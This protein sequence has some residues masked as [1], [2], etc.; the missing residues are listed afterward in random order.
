MGV[1]EQVLAAKQQ[2]NSFYAKKA[3]QKAVEQYTEAEK[4]AGGSE[5]TSV[6]AELAKVLNNRAACFLALGR[7]VRAIADCSNAI[8]LTP[9][10]A[11]AFFRR[12]QAY[13]DCCKFSAAAEDLRKLL[14]LDPTNERGK[15]MLRLVEKKLHKAT[16]SRSKNTN[17]DPAEVQVTRDDQLK[18]NKFGVL[19]AELEEL[20]DS[21]REARKQLRNLEAAC[22]DVALLD[23]DDEDDEVL[24]RVGEVFIKVNPDEAEQI[25]E[26]QKEEAET[27]VAN[28]ESR[29]GAVLQEMELLRTTLYAKFGNAIGL[30]LPRDDDEE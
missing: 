10:Y 27:L 22:E 18:I 11:K 26:R 28:L 3:F 1:L 29:V 13:E 19:N 30:E 17:V 25:V 20:R 4:V 5:D 7:P 16:Q 6:K 21:R 9:D 24:L 23:E 15:S 8:E 12:A 14:E 2:G